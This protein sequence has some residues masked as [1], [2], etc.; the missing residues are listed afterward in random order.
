MLLAAMDRVGELRIGSVVIIRRP[1]RLWHGGRYRRLRRNG[2]ADVFLLKRI[3]NTE[4][5]IVLDNG[6]IVDVAK[7]DA[8]SRSSSMLLRTP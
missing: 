7:E 2:H 6:A 5:K 4:T 1:I 3:Q 8:K